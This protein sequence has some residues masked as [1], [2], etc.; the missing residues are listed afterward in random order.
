[1]TAESSPVPD[2]RDAVA[3]QSDGGEEDEEGIGVR[4]AAAA[5]SVGNNTMEETTT[6]IPMEAAEPSLAD[7]AVAAGAN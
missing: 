7:T 1:M 2:E 5:A 4:Y 6:S 3:V